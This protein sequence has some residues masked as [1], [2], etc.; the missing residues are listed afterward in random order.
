M[1][2]FSVCFI[3]SFSNLSVKAARSAKLN[4]LLIPGFRSGVNE[5]FDLS[6]CHAAFIGS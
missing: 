3:F 4:N 2:Y 6:D 1:K 5:I